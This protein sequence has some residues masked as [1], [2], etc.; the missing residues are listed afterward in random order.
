MNNIVDSNIKRTTLR[1]G[2]QGWVQTSNVKG[3]KYEV[4]DPT[5]NKFV[6]VK[7]NL[8]KEST[9]EGFKD[10]NDPERSAQRKKRN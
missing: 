3:F 5:L 10:V 9:K 8:L 7:T 2:S 6:P 1:D 4:W